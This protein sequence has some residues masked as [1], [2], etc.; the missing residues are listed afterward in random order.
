MAWHP[1]S[2]RQTECV[3]QELDQ[4]LRIFVNKQQDDWHDLL[5]M[6]E[7]QHNNHI[8]SSTKQ[9]PFLI[10][11][12]RL[13]QMGFEPRQCPSKLKIANEFSERMRKAT[14]EAR[15]AIQIAQ[16]EMARHYNCQRTPAP[17]FE[18][19]D[20]VF[21]DASDIQTM[22]PL[23]KL[24]HH[25]LGPFEI[26]KRVGPSAYR[27]KLPLSMRRLHLVFNVIKLTTV[28]E[29]LIPGRRADPPPPP[30]IVDREEQWEV[31]ELLDSRW[32]CQKLQ[33]LIKW[34]GFG[35]EDNSWEDTADVQAPEYI[36]RYH[37][38]HL[39]APRHIR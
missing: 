20:R 31:E 14:E 21:L 10:D 23:A 5:S 8:H 38:Q 37:K 6:A 29:D 11:T 34:K 25:C 39:G 4:F 33:Y 27:L 24:S 17:P 16:E 28:P 12:G 26:D 9:V 19:G 1:Q 32:H 7:F 3:N 36:T 13:P 2:D 22:R 35:C 15:S 30:V 18:P